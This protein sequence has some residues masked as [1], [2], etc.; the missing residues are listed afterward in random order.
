MDSISTFNTPSPEASASGMS[1]PAVIGGAVAAMAVSLVL[2]LLGS[3]LG[4]SSTF[5]WGH[6]SADLSSF[7]VKT[8]IW[9]I[10]MQ[11]IASGFG[12][13]LTGR[14]RTKWA[15]MHTDEVF[16]R[17][18]AH[19]FLAWSLATILTAGFLASAATSAVSGGLHGAM[20]AGAVAGASRANDNSGDPTAYYID[21][22][23]RSNTPGANVSPQD[24]RAETVRILAMGLKDGTVPENDKTYLARL[25]A[26]R[27]G[28]D[29][30]EASQRIDN[31]I[32]QLNTAKEKA[33]QAAFKFFIYTFLSMLVGAF[34]ASVAAAVGGSHRD[35]YN[36]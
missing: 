36:P 29:V 31:V 35:E 14:L 6:S 19:G 27:T 13:Y 7:T 2:L 8:A 4:L 15:N 11:W 30:A 17:D 22:L 21:S 28:I 33:R 20:D 18:T 5:T 16:F 25:I 3:A 26:A 24:T 9:L 23:F 34:I 10:V 12:G 1:W 32:T